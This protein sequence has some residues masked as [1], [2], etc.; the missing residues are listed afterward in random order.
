M[1]KTTATP[2]EFHD[3]VGGDQAALLMPG[4]DY[5]VKYRDT[6]TGKIKLA[7]AVWSGTEFVYCAPRFV[8]PHTKPIFKL[9]MRR[10][11]IQGVCRLSEFEEEPKNEVRTSVL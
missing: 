4:E 5:V 11:Y 8:I 1:T 6:H 7:G 2:L 10:H 3:N 9:S